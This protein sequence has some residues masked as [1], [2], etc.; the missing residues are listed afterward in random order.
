MPAAK[1]T[2]P[3][4]RS[5][6][7]LGALALLAACLYIAFGSSHPATPLFAGALAATALA[8]AQ[9]SLT[10]R[11]PTALE[12]LIDAAAITA[13]AAARDPGMAVWQI[14]T[15][16]SGLVQLSTPGAAIAASIYVLSAIAMPLR[17]D[18][19]LAWHESLSLLLIPL[20]FNLLLLL[21][22]DALL[23]QLGGWASGQTL[24]EH[25]AITGARALVLFAFVELLMGALGFAING[26][27]SRDRRLHELLAACAIHAALSV[28]I[29]GLPQALG[30]API[31]LQA[32]VAVICAALAQAGLWAFV[33]VGTGVAIEAVAGRP[34]TFA[35][36]FLHWN[37]GIRK[38]AFFGAIFV[39]LALLARMAL[40][41]LPQLT[42]GMAASVL[43]AVIGGALAFPFFATVVGSADETPPFLG[44]LAASY[45]APRAYLRGAL[46]GC[47]VL[48]AII[49]DL[50]HRDGLSR[51]AI[52]FA[53]GALAY[54]GVD[55][56]SDGLRIIRRHR[57]KFA[58]W[59]V[60]ALG[61]L[62]GGIVG[63]ALGWYF[64][65]VQL[66]VV[67][68]KLRA[69][70]DLSYA[71]SGRPINAY[72][73]YPLFS[74][75]GV[76]NLGPIGGG[77]SLFFTESLSGVI[78]W[79]LAAPL[80]GINFIVLAA[81]IERSL[82]PLRQL[83][84][85][86]GLDGLVVQTVRVLRWG[87]WMAPV[88]FSFLKMSPD[89]SWYNQDGAIRTI[90]AT[91]NAIVMPAHDFRAWSLV[92]FTGLLAYDWLRI[93]IWFDHMGLRVAT[94][95][96]L[97]FVGGDK[98]DEAAARAAGYAAPARFMP[99]G[100]RRFATWMPLLIPFYIPRGAEW[101]RA[102][103]GAEQLH[104]HAMPAEIGGLIGY[105]VVAG[106]WA[107][108]MAILIM[109]HWT[110]LRTSR[111]ALMPGVP[112]SLTVGRTQFNLSNGA[113]GLKLLADGRGY[114]HIYE[115][116][117]PG[118]P[119]DLTARPIDAMQA[120]GLFFYIR[121]RD[122]DALFSLA[123]EPCHHA[124]PDY[125]I[126]EDRP[127]I[128]TLTNRYAA[129]QA[130]AEIRLAEDDCVELW[131][132]RLKN[133]TD[134]PR[135]LCLTS[136]QELALAE[137]PAY[138]RD[139]DFHALHVATWFVPPLNAIFARNR[140]LR[141]GAGKQVG[142]RMS[143]EIFFHAVRL[144]EKG[145]HFEG[146]EDSRIR[147]LGGG[148]IRLPDGVGEGRARAPEDAGLLYSFDPAASLS[149]DLDLPAHASCELLF[150]NGHAGD[151]RQAAKLAGK[152][153]GRAAP[154]EMALAAIL[155][156]T[157]NLKERRLPADWPF[158][159][160]EKGG[161]LALTPA[162]P[163]PWAH[164]LS[165]SLG[166]G[167][168]V[169]NDGEIHSF[170]GNERQNGLTPFNFEQV[171]TSLPGQIIY[172]VDIDSDEIYSPGL[173][174][175]R[176]PDTYHEVIY[177]KGV[178][179]FRSLSPEIEIELTLFVPP[180]QPA[181][182]R[183]LTLRNKAAVTRRFRIVPYFDL[184][185]AETTFESAGR[186]ESAQDAAANILFFT[187]PTNGFYKGWGF[188]AT[189]LNIEHREVI[190]ARFIGAAGRDLKRPVVAA[191]GASDPHVGD[192]GR[193][194]AACTGLID[195]AA[196][197]EAEI[198]IVFGQAANRAHA[199]TTA[200]RLRDPRRARR[201]LAETREYWATHGPAIEIESNQPH[202]DRLINHWLHYETVAC[203]LNA[204]GGPN[205]RSGAYG[206]RDQLQDVLPLFFSDP[207]FARTQIL[208]HASQQFLEGD[209]LKWWHKTRDGHTGLGQRSRASDVHLWLPYVVTRY[210]AA[211]NDHAILAERTHYLVGPSV[212][213][214]KDSLT[215][216]PRISRD[217]GDLYEHCR[218]ALDYALARFGAHGLPLFGT[219]D[220]N[221]GIDHAG[222]NGHGESV[223][224]GFFLHGILRDFA[225]I[226]AARDGETTA[227]HY[228]A[229][230]E[231]LSAA[232]EKTWEEDHYIIGYADSGAVLDRYGSMTAAWPI[233]TGAVSA[234]RGRAALEGGL[235]HVEKADRILLFDQPFDELSSP[236]P[237][238]IADYPPG[239]RENG[240]QYS[241][242][243]SWL[244]DAYLR[245]AE[246]ADKKGDARRAAEDR[247]RAF[248][249]WRKISPL[250]KL[251]GEALAVYGLA[252]H[253]QAADI[254]DGFGHDG[255]G[256]WS[257]YTGAAAR[258]LSAAYAI[259]GI[260]MQAGEIIVP[261][262]IFAPKGA[263]TLTA[264]RV[265]GKTYS[266]PAAMPA[267]AGA[268]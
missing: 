46:C 215:Y 102:W 113:I 35:A 115:T 212:P 110:R 173:V 129:I 88:I 145:A 37:K 5:F 54:G 186:I 265:R 143:R 236:F 190:R 132:V 28:R 208:L 224:L 163:R 160:S 209:V 214:D 50:P 228:L 223:W 81:L 146:Y 93:L 161:V 192:D 68:T 260:T 140:L 62:L 199:T 162:T 21:D 148:D 130:Q 151:E 195:I 69:Y 249:L 15:Q 53:S 167:A 168:I 92:V 247:G 1:I 12:F 89:P 104:N 157:R 213:R 197:G 41:Y 51:F 77:V 144:P 211:T 60:Y 52:A 238:R 119:I 32:P 251:E 49:A 105:Y 103:T 40:T 90:A 242:G 33:Y 231:R 27:L 137:F 262:D 106:L 131:T 187:N 39:A 220:W 123:Y 117:R 85:Q 150:V 124:A 114:R 170:A 240:G 31:L 56:L 246:H 164:V 241:H 155:R 73:I 198:A 83:F 156:Q 239:L 229:R 98:V 267:K 96:N 181:D 47:G 218:L 178:A 184:A 86:E 101:D 17:E 252:P 159:F 142:Q 221:D 127:G 14:P 13:I 74:K 3:A 188:A 191:T 71:T 171:P 139:R 4:L 172:V 6:S 149:I 166:Y 79:S 177:E 34:P 196:G 261:D 245:L 107:A 206:F 55:F 42:S 22:A 66:D 97:T 194:I 255:R 226:I 193:R 222:F 158:A 38:G 76:M 29:A 20:L 152:Y 183:L 203:R 61:L 58:N 258:M 118:A 128:L 2:E 59:H 217:D 10:G 135:R 266:A 57:H 45:R 253:Q 100:I 179:I 72:V 205:Q 111:A 257:W 185:L 43:L 147:F 80:F 16:W 94:L 18:R 91:F 169:S 235:A 120:R 189:N 207:G 82:R 268:E 70:G 233:L 232:L 99:D 165:N 134:E 7:A 180:D 243:A 202:F 44:R 264:L 95:V 112:R 234:E 9:S 225:P 11:F 64:D 204:R 201:A 26:R 244:I 219:G 116:A 254:S 174:P 48:I 109:Q 23:Q 126:S 210:L 25:A 263:L 138:V 108:A 259:L 63:G 182:V 125:R 67:A 248:E 176:R 19:H 78:N 121:D 24:Q 65:A 153:I 230:A 227:R 237:G 133:L 30:H 200:E 250:D 154:D 75:W 175:L 122:S 256:G 136:F 141:D 84:S 36:A 216:V 8:L 87:L